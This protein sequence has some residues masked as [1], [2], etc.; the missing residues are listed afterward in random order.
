M[1]ARAT[2]GE[3]AETMAARQRKRNKNKGQRSGNQGHLDLAQ[4]P[5]GEKSRGQP[6]RTTG[7]IVFHKSKKRK[8][9]KENLSAGGK[10]MF[11]ERASESMRWYCLLGYT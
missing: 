3:L 4:K 5:R 11:L 1:F 2:D 6:S 7:A 10:T 9:K 8:G